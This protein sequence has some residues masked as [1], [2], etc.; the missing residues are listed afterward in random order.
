MMTV[1]FYLVTNQVLKIHLNYTNE[2]TKLKNQSDQGK[3]IK[4]LHESVL[5]IIR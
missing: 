5:I 4:F 2:M 3:R 1:L